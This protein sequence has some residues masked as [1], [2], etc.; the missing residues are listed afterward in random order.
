MPGRYP[1]AMSDRLF[2]RLCGHRGHS[3]GAPENTLAAFRL[4]HELGAGACE[5]DTVLTADGEIVVLHD[6]LLDRTTNG[7]G[8]ARDFTAAQVAALDAGSWYAPAFAGEQVPS[9][10]DALAL[11]RELDLTYEI[12]IKERRDY[13]AYFA[14]LARGLLDPA[15][16][17]RVTLISF[18]HVSLRDAKAAIPG[19]KTAG[20]VH[21]RYGDPVAVA[22]SAGLDELCIDL[23]QFFPDD[24]EALHA[25]GILIRCHA[26]SPPVMAQAE[27]AGL[28]W[29]DKLRSGLR[30]GLIDILSGDDIDWIRDFADA[31]LA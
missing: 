13:P 3:V 25:A 18:D 10:A 12:E 29:H 7:Q 27:R 16:L 26:Y 22:R 9:L 4:A 21:E 20:I 23:E 14:A 1:R 31:A 30:R 19:L 28:D 2:P 11:A 15:D 5:I 6:L 8:A 24:A 17:A